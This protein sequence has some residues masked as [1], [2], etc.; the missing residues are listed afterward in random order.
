MVNKMK[1]LP[2]SEEE[3]ARQKRI[4]ARALKQANKVAKLMGF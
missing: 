2:T 4:N 3:E 1:K